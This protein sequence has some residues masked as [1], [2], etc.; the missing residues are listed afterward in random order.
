[1]S[2]L[3][4]AREFAEWAITR[5]ARRVRVGDVE[6]EMWQPERQQENEAKPT[7]E[8]ERKRML[9]LRYHSGV[10]PSEVE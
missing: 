1:M 4:E 5:G 9:E 2:A 10:V 6:L 3:A 8:Q 7:P